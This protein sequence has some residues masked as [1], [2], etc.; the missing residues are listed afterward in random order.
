M[1]RMFLAIVLAT[2]GAGAA[3][4]ADARDIGILRVGYLAA[5]ASSCRAPDASSP[6]GLRAYARHV[7]GRLGRTVQGCAFASADAASAALVGGQVDL[8]PLGADASAK[9][10]ETIR[11]LLTPRSANGVGRVLTVAVTRV[12]GTPFEGLAN[13]ADARVVFGG[14]NEVA[15]GGPL[16]ALVDN[17]AP[18]TAFR[19]ETVAA[20]PADAA[21][22]LRAGNADI[23]VLHAAAWQRLCR[24]DGP[25]E[26]PCAGLQEVWR[27]RPSADS[28][29]AVRRDIPDELRFRL[30]GIHVAL[31]LE[32]PEAFRWIAPGASELQPIEAL[33][34]V[35]PPAR[36]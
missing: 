8:A 3:D 28:A 32:A 19:A 2:I 9:S 17:G 29:L 11:P 36:P 4:A 24:G 21:A 15:R 26:T 20:S 25:R 31:H 22:L 23:M 18:T 34:R 5:E 12:G 1:K 7:S 27:G 35:R 6:V 30:V 33:A 13:L 14:A 16:R 10:A